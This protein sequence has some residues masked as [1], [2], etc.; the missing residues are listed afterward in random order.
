MSI[1]TVFN[2]PSYS[3]MLYTKSNI[4][5]PFLNSIGKPLFTRSSEFP[6]NQ[7]YSLGSPSQPSISETASMTAPE[8]TSVARTQDTNVTQIFQ[9]SVGVSYLKLSSV[10]LMSGVNNEKQTP[11]PEDELNFQK[12]LAMQG[13]ANDIEYSFLNGQYQKASASSEANKTRGIITACTTNTVANSE[14]AALTKEM[15][16]TL[17]KSVFN[18][19]GSVDGGIL[20]CDAAQKIAISN[21]YEGK[22]GYVA[23]LSRNIGGMSIDTLVTDFG[24]VGV[25]TNI[26]MPS[27]TILFYNPSVCRP[28][29]Q[30]VPNKG[31][32]FY[33]PLSKDGAAERG[34]IYGQIGIDYGPEWF[35]G[36]IKGLA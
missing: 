2:C 20:M 1:A 10:G 28:V 22:T 24:N 31:N 14:S 16:K 9:R 25:I 35:H 8:E 23:P 27:G 33:E 18:N 12:A 15:L 21:L 6:L 30:P 19:G 4:K 7:A 32:F 13:I 34:Q 29:E 36:V 5:T 11:S 3:G 17:L 26:A